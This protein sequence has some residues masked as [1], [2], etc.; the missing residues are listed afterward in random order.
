MT[1]AR[2]RITPAFASPISSSG[3]QLPGI[4]KPPLHRDAAVGRVGDGP[5]SHAVLEGGCGAAASDDA[6]RALV[7]KVGR[8]LLGVMIPR[9]GGLWICYS[10]PLISTPQYHAASW[11]RCS[12]ML[13]TLCA[14]QEQMGAGKVSID[15]TIQGRVWQRMLLE[16]GCRQR[17][18]L[19]WSQ[20]L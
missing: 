14:K 18:G 20:M 6:G 7:E 16:R 2:S 1:G 17:N 13:R 5:G 11:R 10:I 3:P 12:I 15:S 4:D 9:H 8:A 19:G